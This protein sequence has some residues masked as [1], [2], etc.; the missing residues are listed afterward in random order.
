MLQEERPWHSIYGGTISD[1]PI[2]SSLTEFLEEAVE[3]HRDNVALTQG[4][5]KISDGVAEL[6]AMSIVLLSQRI[7]SIMR[8]TILFLLFGWLSLF[9][10]TPPYFSLLLDHSACVERGQPHREPQLMVTLS[11]MLACTITVSEPESLKMCSS[12]RPT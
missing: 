8:F 1:E 12:S 9:P 7:P 3:K 2:R 10:L 5:R 6:V 11:Y 4:E